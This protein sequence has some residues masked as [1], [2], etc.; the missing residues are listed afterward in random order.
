MRVQVNGSTDQVYYLLTDHLGSTAITVGTNNSKLAEIRYKPWGETRIV[1]GT[2]PTDYRFTGQ[3]EENGIGLYFYQARFY[4]PALDVLR[5]R[6]LSFQNNLRGFK[7]GI[8]M[9]MQI[10]ILFDTMIRLVIAPIYQI[11]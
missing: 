9:L 5:E 2:T 4:D 1:W 6:I 3:R 11:A 8:V 10:T 7:R